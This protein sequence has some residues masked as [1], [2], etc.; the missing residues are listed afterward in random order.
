M[1][2]ASEVSRQNAIRGSVQQ[3]AALLLSKTFFFY[4]AQEFKFLLSI[5]RCFS[6]SF[7][8]FSIPCCLVEINWKTLWSRGNSFMYSRNHSISEK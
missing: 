1:I 8:L 5:F 6:F 3:S 4:I 2:S 7:S